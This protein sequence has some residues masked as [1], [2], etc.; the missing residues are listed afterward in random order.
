MRYFEMRKARIEIIPMIDIMLF[1]LVFFIMVTLRMIPASG[2][3]S[4]LPQSSTAQDLPHP[5]VVVTLL[6]DGEIE[7][8]DQK[9]T[10]DALTTK[11]ES[12][13]DPSKTDVTIAGAAHASLQNLLDVMDAC[14]KAGITQLGIAARDKS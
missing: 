2:I 10:L 14:R 9:M 8:D 4:Q 7:V 6:A 12:E 1:L 11:L 5:K 3:S 13:P